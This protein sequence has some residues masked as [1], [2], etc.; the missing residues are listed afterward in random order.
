MKQAFIFI[1]DHNNYNDKKN[2]GHAHVLKS[3]PNTNSLVVNI[4]FSGNNMT[5]PEALNDLQAA[6][7][8]SQHAA[9]CLPSRLINLGLCPLPGFHALLRERWDPNWSLCLTIC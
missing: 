5:M 4:Y 2:D 7:T 9:G 3:N 8:S 6:R 1:N